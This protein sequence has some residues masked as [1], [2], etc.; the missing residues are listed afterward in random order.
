MQLLK[1]G[2]VGLG[3]IAQKVYLPLLSQAKSWELVGAYSPNQAKAAPIC[4]QYRIQLFASLQDLAR[5][6]D[7]VFVHAAT[8]AH[9][10][11]ATYL[12]Q[13]GVHVYID[14]PLAETLEQGEQLVELAH[15][16]KR[17]L[18]VGFNRRFAPF[19]QVVKA[20]ISSAAFVTFSKHRMQGI[21]N[22]CRF[23]MLDDYIHLLDTMLWLGQGKL[24]PVSHLIQQTLAHELEY[25]QSCYRNSKTLFTTQMHR[26]AGTQAETLELVG[27]NQV[28]R[29][30]DMKCLET[31][32]DGMLEVTSAGNWQSI[33][34][35][36]GFAPMIDY[37][38]QC[39][40]N[41]TTPSVSGE[42][43]LIAQRILEQELSA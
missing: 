7:V 33:L 22:P 14:K 4:R 13:Q 9:A 6:C 32:H 12:L 43:A 26:N 31:E 11:I 23:T 35:L 36:R 18:M 19:Y 8:A 2:M 37:Y 16:Q 15:Q 17:A 42:Q 38:L 30:R 24:Q 25:A 1:V 27:T 20:N 40:A 5:A 21:G 10:E 29:V 28:I 3:S 34:E 41:Q 39:V